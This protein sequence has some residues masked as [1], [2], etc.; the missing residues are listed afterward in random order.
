[1]P[2]LPEVQTVVNFIKDKL[3]EKNII[4]IVPVWPK[5]FDN[6]S[7]HDFYSKVK[8][9][10]IIDVKRRAKFIIIELENFILAIHLR[11]TG[12]LY[13][14]SKGLPKHTSAII[15]L[16]S[17]KTLIFEDVRKFG[18][19]YLYNDL[20]TINKRHGYEPLS[21]SFTKEIFLEILSS[22]KR[23]IKSLLLDQ[24]K[25]VGLGN[26][27]VDESL[28]L[29]QIHPKSISNKIPQKKVFILYNSIRHVLLKAIS[30][31][32]TTIINYTY[33]EGK[34]GNNADELNIYGKK[35]FT[36]CVCNTTIKKIK[37]SN[38]GTYICKC[39]KIHSAK[40]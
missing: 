17:N 32:G 7:E 37:V 19:F 10:K 20:E 33:T 29:S 4:K 9:T 40:K 30:N 14:V 8:N 25:V 15:K 26:I 18:R 12:K 38:R 28:W 6:F 24:S 22:C 2:E 1:M 16:N 36:C 23:G 3:I 27:Y 21:E 31:N 39:Q 35:G 13:F 11:M 34:T 5:V